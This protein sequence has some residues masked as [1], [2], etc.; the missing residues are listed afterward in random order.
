MKFHGRLY[1]RQISLED[2]SDFDGKQYCTGYTEYYFYDSLRETYC[3]E[4]QPSYECHYLR[5]EFTISPDCPADVMDGIHNT[6]A[7]CDRGDV[8]YVHCCD[9]P[10]GR[11]LGVDTA[12]D[13][14]T[15]IE[16]MQNVP[17]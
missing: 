10:P 2:F 1:A 15:W 3:C 14:E 11:D 6:E 4:M 9:M 17:V 8:I 7:T 12:E 16:E 5:G 13:Y